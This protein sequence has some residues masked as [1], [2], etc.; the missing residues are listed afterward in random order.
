MGTIKLNIQTP[1]K[2]RILDLSF[3]CKQKASYYQ[4]EFPTQKVLM[5]IISGLNAFPHRRNS[6][7]WAEK[8]LNSLY[9]TAPK[10]H[11]FLID[12][13]GRSTTSGG[14]ISK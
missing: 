13:T 9:E 7:F 1:M 2:D 5:M 4:D 11:S 12:Q 14:V 10:R 6:T 3:A 8:S